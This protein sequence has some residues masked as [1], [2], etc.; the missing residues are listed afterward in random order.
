MG[1][2]AASLGWGLVVGASLLAGA[3]AAAVFRLPPRVA[4]TLTAFGGG[5]LLAAVALELVPEADREAGAGLT[6]LGLLAG[7]LVYVG[8]DGWLNRDEQMRAMRR[9]AHALSSSQRSSSRTGMSR[10]RPRRTGSVYVRWS[11]SRAGRG[12]QLRCD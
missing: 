2:L 7:T 1:E 12:Q 5:I 11:R 8:A 3:L 10:R 9:S 6:A 4:A